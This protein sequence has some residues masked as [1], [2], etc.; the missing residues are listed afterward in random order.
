MVNKIVY[1]RGEALEFLMAERVRAELKLEHKRYTRTVSGR[2]NVPYYEVSTLYYSSV[3]VRQHW[4]FSSAETY[5]VHA[6][7]DWCTTSHFSNIQLLLTELYLEDI[8]GP[9][10]VDSEY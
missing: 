8:C 2:E 1:V 6:Y 5:F 7:E 3:L 4:F 10:P 9:V